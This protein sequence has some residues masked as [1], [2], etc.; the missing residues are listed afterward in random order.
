[1]SWGPK[2]GPMET[3]SR[4]SDREMAAPKPKVGSLVYIASRSE[5]RTSIYQNYTSKAALEKNLV[6]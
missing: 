6:F 3:T 1:M 5:S 4:K 2:V